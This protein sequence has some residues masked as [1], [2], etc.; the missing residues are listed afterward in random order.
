MKRKIILRDY[1]IPAVEHIMKIPICV[2]AITP[3]GGKTEVSIEVIS[4]YLKKYKNHK[5]LVLT[6]STN[7]LLDNY[8]DR[9]NE[10]EVDFTYSKDFDPNASVHISLPHSEHKIKGCYDF[11]IVDEAHENYFAPR[12]KRLIESIKATKQLLLTGTPSPFIREGGYDIYPVATNELLEYFAKLNLELVASDYGWMGHYNSKNE[13][14]DNFIF[15]RINT[16]KTLEN[17]L[18][19]LIERLRTKFSPKE[20]NHPSFLSKA[21]KWLW[22]YDKIGK[23]IITCKTIKQADLVYDILKNEHNLNVGISHSENDIESEIVSDFKNNKF[24]VLVVVN[25]ARLGYDDETLFN[26]IDMSGT[27][28]PDIIYQMFCRV[29]RGSPDD[30]KYYIKVTPKKLV[31][32]A[33]T[34]LAVCAALMLTDKEFLLKYNGKNFS[35]IKIPVLKTSPNKKPSN[36]GSGGRKSQSNVLPVLNLNVIDTFKNVLH[37]LN[38]SAS[39]YKMTTIGHVKHTLGYSKNRPP[40]TFEDIIESARGDLSLVE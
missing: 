21:K 15:N 28:N 1:Q 5:V 13:V 19:K 40:L 22:T 9:L 39:I 4:R 38:N 35:Q 29:L 18:E 24:K 11:I 7:V 37:D 31:N 30:E 36:D 6:H 23:T 12:E 14:K 20:F 2:L 3:G 17:V 26:I 16:R 8:Y 34:H 33:M 10:V 25:R 27:H 32:M